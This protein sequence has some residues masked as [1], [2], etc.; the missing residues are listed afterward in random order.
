MKQDPAFFGLIFE[1]WCT[2]R[3]SE[4]IKEESNAGISQ[5]MADVKVVLE[6]AAKQGLIGVR[7]P[8]E[9]EGL[10][11]IILA[12][13]HGIV[14]QLFHS[15]DIGSNQVMCNRLKKCSWQGFHRGLD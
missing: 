2:A 11:R 9:L 6:S 4:R 12:S 13:Y 10:A 15:P 3:R 8:V 7:D 5:R 14:L 1:T